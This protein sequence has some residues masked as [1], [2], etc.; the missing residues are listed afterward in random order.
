MLYVI[1]EKTK[2]KKKVKQKKQEENNKKKKE[3]EKEYKESENGVYRL[4]YNKGESINYKIHQQF[5]CR[6]EERD[7]R[8]LARLPFSKRD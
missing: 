8:Y 3:Y 2:N 6:I 4:A 7:P 5:L 1:Y